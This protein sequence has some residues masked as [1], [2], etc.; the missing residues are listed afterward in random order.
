MKNISAVDFIR[1]WPELSSDEV[2]VDVRETE[3]FDDSHIP[4]SVN[5]PLSSIGRG[6]EELKKYSKIYLVCETGGRSSYA[7]EVLKTAEVGTID[8]TG[9]LSALREAGVTLVSTDKV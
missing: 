6:L 5:L 7:H 3:E 9:G 4:N 8:V 2:V 1:I